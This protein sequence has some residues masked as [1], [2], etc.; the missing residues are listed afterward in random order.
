MEMSALLALDVVHR[1]IGGFPLCLSV[2]RDLDRKVARH[3]LSNDPNGADG[4]AP[5]PLSDG[6][7]AFPS[8]S[9]VTQ[10][11]CQGLRQCGRRQ[12]SRSAGDASLPPMAKV[13]IFNKK[14]HAQSCRAVLVDRRRRA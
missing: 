12:V 14:E 7:E 4:L 2:Q 5:G 8:E 10:S 1:A 13:C 9:L 3:F 6:I 11:D